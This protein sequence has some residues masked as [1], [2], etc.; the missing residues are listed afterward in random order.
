[1]ST[2]SMAQ[3]TS[4]LAWGGM[5]HCF[6]NQGLSSFFYQPTHTA[7]R[8]NVGLLKPHHFVG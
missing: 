8:Q 7:G 2:S 1:M 3:T 5:R 6:F 4:A